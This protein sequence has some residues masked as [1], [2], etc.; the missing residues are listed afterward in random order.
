MDPKMTVAEV[1]AFLEAEFP[2]I[3]GRFE[4]MSIG[5][6]TAN[7]RMVARESD[8]RPGGT[9]SGPAMFA[10]ADV[11]YYVVT[12]AM[13]GPQAL[14]VTTNCNINFMRKPEPTAQ[15]QNTRLC[16]QGCGLWFA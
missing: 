16:N 3:D 12:L 11:A 6:M 4:L 8:L 14:T 15:F 2:Q 10:L 13:I 5:S 7:V 9:V 1:T